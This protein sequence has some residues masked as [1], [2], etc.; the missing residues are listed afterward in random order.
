[1][2]GN[3]QKIIVGLKAGFEFIV[4]LQIGVA[5]RKKIFETETEIKS[6]DSEY[7]A[8]NRQNKKQRNYCFRKTQVKHLLAF[9][10]IHMLN[11]RSGKKSKDLSFF[12][13]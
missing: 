4:K 10:K 12:I 7:S 3:E 8:D 1:V 6:V 5:L 9:V 2:Y 11:N 13:K